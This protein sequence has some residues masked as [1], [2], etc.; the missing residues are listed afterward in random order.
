[1]AEEAER[2]ADRPSASEGPSAARFATAIERALAHQRN[3]EAATTPSEPWPAVSP[4]AAPE[5]LAPTEDETEEEQVKDLSARTK[6]TTFDREREQSQLLS[7]E[8]ASARTDTETRKTERDNELIT[9]TEAEETEVSQLE[10]LEPRL[11]DR[12]RLRDLIRAELAKHRPRESARAALEF[13]AEATVIGPGFA[14]KGIQV[15]NELWSE[16]AVRR[17]V[18]ELHQS[19][20]RLFGAVENGSA[21]GPNSSGDEAPRT[22][23][24]NAVKD[25][26]DVAIREPLMQSSTKE[27]KEQPIEPAAPPKPINPIGRVAIEEQAKDIVISYQTV[28]SESRQEQKRVFKHLALDKTDISLG[29]AI[30]KAIEAARMQDTIGEGPG[31]T[32]V[33]ITFKGSPLTATANSDPVDIAVDWTSH[34]EQKRFKE[35]YDRTEHQLREAK[36]DLRQS[37]L[38]Q[39]WICALNFGCGV[40][41]GGMLV[42]MFAGL[43]FPEYGT[44]LFRL[45][46]SFTG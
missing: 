13:V 43:S 7:H 44:H 5:P 31:S 24:E 12:E 38:H 27:V 22:A 40:A 26:N 20:R 30:Q 42:S 2:A 45:L 1:M 32:V 18:E 39:N 14:S 3:A 41:I 21:A 4:T 25:L 29:L 16:D 33:E 9:S 34:R 28:H 19:H 17:A 37:D 8:L 36:A 10:A 35:Q 11:S 15:G 46:H 6:A 23:D